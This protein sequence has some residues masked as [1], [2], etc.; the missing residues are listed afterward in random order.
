MVCRDANT[1]HARKVNPL[2]ISTPEER[3][4]HHMGERGLFLHLYLWH[5]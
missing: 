5:V 4:L 3:S 1:H 2:V